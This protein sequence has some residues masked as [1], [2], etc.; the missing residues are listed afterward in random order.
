MNEKGR[1]TNNKRTRGGAFAIAAMCA[2]LFMLA[3][4]V[5]SIYLYR[6][7]VKAVTDELSEATYE[8]YEK[9]VIMVTSDD[10]SDFWQSV[11]EAAK[12]AGKEHGIFVDM[13]SDGLNADYTKIQLFEMAIASHPDSIIVEGDESEEMLALLE[14]AEHEGITVVTMLN[15]IQSPYRV[16]FVGISNYNLGQLYG[17]QVL[18]L[19]EEK[20]QVLILSTATINSTTESLIFSGV[21]ETVDTA[22]E[23]K[24][25][26]NLQTAVI[27]N[28]D[29]FAAEEYVRKLFLN[30]EE[31]ELPQVIICLDELT[32]TCVYQ[33]LIDYNMVGQVKLLGYYDSDTILNGIDY[34]VINATVSINTEQLGSLCLEA[35]DEYANTGY[36]SD[37]YSVETRL[38]TSENLSEYRS[39]EV[40]VDE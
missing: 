4:T 2:V 31:E 36:V 26:I 33:A 18:G 7:R 17:Y 40:S 5:A 12:S 27:N 24:Q 39:R 32:T 29:A 14:R 38:I 15:D 1:N 30:T 35:L 20:A 19:V 37:Y 3:V 8:T 21:Q 6:A 13:I 9:Y 10:D 23:I 11:Y 22:A 28:D 16:S 34:G 25:G